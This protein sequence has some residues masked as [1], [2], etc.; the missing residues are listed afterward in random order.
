VLTDTRPAGSM[1]LLMPLFR[2]L[3]AR[4]KKKGVEQELLKKYYYQ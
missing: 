2:L 4:A 3:A 1:G